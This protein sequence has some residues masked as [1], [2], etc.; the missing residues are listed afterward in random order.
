MHEGYKKWV[1]A[2]AAAVVVVMNTV[3]WAL[4]TQYS[5][6]SEHVHT[7]TYVHVGARTYVHMC[8]Y[9]RPPDNWN[10]HDTSMRMIGHP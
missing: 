8:M 2:A 4:C 10:G 1:A 5:I 3:Y 9:V 7:L 6:V